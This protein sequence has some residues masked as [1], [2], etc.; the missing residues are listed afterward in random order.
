M[1]EDTFS[2]Q[3]CIFCGTSHS[4]ISYAFGTVFTGASEGSA[5]SGSASKWGQRFWDVS[6][7]ASG[8]TGSSLRHT[9]HGAGPKDA[10]AAKE[11]LSLPLQ[12]TSSH[13]E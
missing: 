2:A 8:H 10:A 12:S 3:L 9:R 13:R 5:V 6:P 1:R 7:L 11:T 4:C